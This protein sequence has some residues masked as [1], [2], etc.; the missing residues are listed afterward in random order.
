MS[1]DA[2]LA[3]GRRAHLQLM[4]DRI[5]IRRPGAP[6]FDSTTGAESRA[7]ETIYGPS[8]AADVK[9][10]TVAAGEEQAGEREQ[11]TR[12]YDVKLPAT[13]AVRFRPDDEITVDTSDDPTFAEVVLTVVDVQHGGRRTALH[14]I[15]EDRT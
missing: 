13:T 4:R 12:R 6:V 2:A 8:A 9:H 15:A 7:G 1:I 11:T 14:L 10:M 3:A 5:T